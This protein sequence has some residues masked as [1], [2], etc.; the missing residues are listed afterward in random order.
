LYGRQVRHGN[1]VSPLYDRSPAPMGVADLGVLNN[2]GTATPYVLNTPSFEGTLSL[3]SLNVFYLD[4]QAPDFIGAQLNA[5]LTNVTLFGDTNYTFWNQNVVT[6]SDRTHL[7]EFIDNIWNFSDP[8]LSLSPNA[9]NLT[10]PSGVQ[11]GSTFYYALGPVIN[12]SMPFSVHLYL[13]SSKI[14]QGGFPYDSTWFNYS[15]YNASNFVQGGSYDRVIYNSQDPANRSG[16]I[17]PP[18]YQ[19]NGGQPTPTGY[20]PYDAEMVLCG[21][22]GGSTTSVYG[23]GGTVALQFL[24]RTNARYQIVPSAIS[25]GSATG[26]T[27]EGASEWY[28]AGET[29]HLSPGPTFPEPLWNSSPTASSGHLTLSSTV[30]PSTAF[31]FLNQS[32]AF[33]ASWAAWAPVN[34]LGGV[35]YQL[36]V[37][38]YTGEFLAS[39]YDPLP[40]SVL[41]SQSSTW[42]VSGALT[43]HT[44]TGVYT[45]LLARSNAELGVIA[46]GGAGTSASPYQLPNAQTGSLDPI[47]GMANDFG[48]PV[49]PGL[50]LRHTSAHVDFANP[51]SFW[52]QYAGPTLRSSQLLGL[53]TSNNLQLQLDG[54]S[55]VTLW[56]A[57]SITGWLS[58]N[59]QSLAE[60]N[61]M[62]WNSTG[63]LVGSN[64]FQ[65]QGSSMLL[66]GGSGNVVWGNQFLEGTVPANG[67]NASQPSGLAEYESADTVFN[68]FF[69]VS[70][71]ALSPSTTIYT[72]TYYQGTSASYQNDWN[73]T[74]RPSTQPWIV[75]GHSLYGNI[76]GGTTQGGNYWSNLGDHRNPLHRVPY[77]NGHALAVGGD[78][79]PLLGPAQGGPGN[80]TLRFAES[81]LP[82][83]TVW[84]V[85]VNGFAWNSSTPYLNESEVSG[86]YAYTVMPVPG[87]VATPASGT[88]V[89]GNADVYVNISFTTAPPPPQYSLVFAVVGYSGNVTITLGS[90]AETGVG[91]V[92]FSEPNGSY[93]FAVSPIPNYSGPT[94]GSV[95][96]AGPTTYPLSFA[97][98]NGVVNG[99]VA[100]STAAVRLN[101]ILQPQ[102]AQFTMAVPAGTASVEATASGYF[103]FFSNVSVA[104]GGLVQ[105]AITLQLIPS[106]SPPPVYPVSFVEAGLSDGTNW[107]VEVGSAPLSGSHDTIVIEL[108][109]GTYDLMVNSVANYTVQSPPTHFTVQGGPE[110]IPIAFLASVGN[111]TIIVAPGSASLLVAGHPAALTNGQVTLPVAPGVFSLSASAPGF[112]SY[113]NNVSV[114]PGASVTVRVVLAPSHPVPAGPTWSAASLA[115]I[116]LLAVAAALLFFGL[117][118]YRQRSRPTRPDPPAPPR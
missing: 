115:A 96:V 30:S 68:N 117:L 1:T 46:T 84:G 57:A 114:G 34:P 112:D 28:D 9:F 59:L 70:D 87:F 17:P 58:P 3:S 102:G 22:G 10:G 64:D 19:V 4:N 100:P 48:F 92:V 18:L 12:I 65:S 71:P 69:N 36:P 90:V 47:F 56:G 72:E 40:F 98:M 107:S 24:N 118:H 75:N 78:Y 39:D 79:L 81:G 29:V 80:A 99:T 45:P 111:L 43:S 37:A 14:L 55:N 54:T 63:T 91:S 44:A 8:S 33:N 50:L 15:I 105:I 83:A 89:V 6:Y 11:V 62:V 85:S 35:T 26:E 41:G 94:G 21:P 60:A 82:S 38:D 27:I 77:T 13:N 61:L 2:S 97:P 20:I 113:F 110:T 103:P 76:L 104:P 116:A 53:P 74:L 32:G 5:I 95:T 66:Y 67:Y 93:P 7:L 101:G 52:I 23:I 88:A 25:L 31:A 51:P 109:D 16:P 42:S 73:V 86:S 108:G 106:V 49:F